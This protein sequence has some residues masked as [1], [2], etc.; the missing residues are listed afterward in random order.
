MRRVLNVAVLLVLAS[1][2]PAFAQARGVARTPDHD[3]IAAQRGDDG[4]LPHVA[5]NQTRPRGVRALDCTD[6]FGCIENPDPDGGGYTQGGCNCSRICYEGHSG[7]NLSVASNG[8]IAGTYP[9]LCKS[10]SVSG[11]CGW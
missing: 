7:C 9:G 1:S 2:S 11:G 6:E 10:C 3:V 4:A 5:R 8:C